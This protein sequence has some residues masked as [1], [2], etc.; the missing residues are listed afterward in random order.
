MDRLTMT[1]SRK[2]MAGLPSFAGINTARRTAPC[3]ASSGRVLTTRRRPTRSLPRPACVPSHPPLLLR[4]HSHTS[5]IRKLLYVRRRGRR[6]VLPAFLLLPLQSAL[7]KR[8]QRHY[9]GWRA[10]V[11]ESALATVTSAV[12]EITFSI[13][14]YIRI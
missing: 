4:A 10:G 3:S 11:V 7:V 2:T 8:G 13:F 14:F 9:C 12:L 1:S 6:I 5:N